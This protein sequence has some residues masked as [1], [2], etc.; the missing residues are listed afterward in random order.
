MRPVLKPAVARAWRGSSTLQLGADPDG[1]TLVEGLGPGDRQLLEVMDG[2]SDLPALRRLAA[3]A[4]LAE[5]RAG[6]LVQVL[7]DAGALDDAGVT[8]APL[9]ALHP[10][11]RDRLRPDLATWSLV[12]RC[13]DAGIGLLARRQAASVRIEGGGRAGAALASLLSAAA[14]GTVEVLD[15]VPASP[16]DVSPGGIGEA[17]VGLPRGEAAS[18]RA[19]PGARARSPRAVELVV[20]AEPAPSGLLRSAELVRAGQAHLVLS[21]RDTVGVVGPLVL[22]GRSACAECLDLARASRDP[23]WPAVLAQLLH[24]SQPWSASGVETI[25]ATLVAAHAALHVLAYL[26]LG[27]A[28]VATAEPSAVDATWEVSLPFG[29]LRRRSWLPHPLCRCGAGA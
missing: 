1:G 4:G 5:G 28:A 25:L 6:E 27:A 26:D 10:S 13:P 15:P 20:L 17:D 3:R 22:P 8:G 16:A 29:V 24:R 18:R 9:A 23:G 11:E 2:T 19:A 21:M 12:H 7:T 14:V